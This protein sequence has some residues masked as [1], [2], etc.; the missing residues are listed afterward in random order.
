MKTFLTIGLSVGAVGSVV[1]GSLAVSS[2]LAADGSQ[3]EDVVPASAIAF[4]KVD[5]NPSVG[6]KLNVLR[7]MRKFPEIKDEG[8]DLKSTLVESLIE[9]GDLDLSYEAD[10]EPWL[11]DRA[12]IAVVPS[13]NNED[14]VAPLVVL[15][16]TDQEA[17][18]AALDKAEKELRADTEAMYSSMGGSPDPSTPEE[19]FATLEQ[20][21]VTSEPEQGSW[22]EASPHGEP[23]AEP[24]GEPDTTVGTEPSNEQD[25]WSGMTSG[26]QPGTM[27]GTEQ[28]AWSGT[29]SGT[30]PGTMPSNET[31]T[32]SGSYSA[33]G[34][35]TASDSSSV[36]EP[37][38]IPEAFA[39][40]EPG[41]V[42]DPRP[43][44]SAGV[45]DE[46]APPTP[47]DLD[48][49][50]YA[51]RDGYVFLSEHQSDVDDAAVAQQVLADDE[52]FSADKAAI[53]GTDQIVL[54]WVNVGR[55]YDIVPE[56]EKAD[57]AEQ[58]GS[59]RPS[60]RLVAGVHAEPDAVEAV[61]RTVDLEAAGAEAL[62]AG[63]KGTGLVNDLPPNTSVAFSATGLGDVAADLWDRYGES[64]LDES[65]EAEE[66]GLQL[67]DDLIAVLGKEAAVGVVLD[68][69]ENEISGTGRV[70]TDEAARALELIDLFADTAS[71]KVHSTPAPDGYVFSTDPDHMADA[72]NGDMT[73]GDNP[74][75]AKAVPDADDASV[76][77]FVD[78]PDVLAILDSFAPSDS[79]PEPSP[80]EA[81]GATATGE[82]GN[83]EFK[84][85]LT[86]R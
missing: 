27:P 24:S 76:L 14:G 17:M 4:V 1:A 38:A 71:E 26:T 69:P 2:F 67:P 52:A 70:R 77:L 50:D 28:D 30:E 8:E 34:P 86:F 78:I 42:L 68:D 10:I 35:G 46:V 55:V 62:A 51:I 56:D 7:L 11:G 29:T 40:L 31:G 16:F 81:F 45:V 36:V 48:P 74:A 72:F 19:D 84:L 32:Y 53:D 83:G 44:L 80:L 20:G 12:A 65:G 23:A 73:L 18:V 57:F 5:L 6:Q 39:T 59:A 43:S 60:G 58:F 3:P 49:F 13:S 15:E 64:F 37:S 75:F 22:A 54:G 85:R 61:G 33:V 79:E 9:E 47:E 82:A 21:V 25:A 41:V 66:L 63:G